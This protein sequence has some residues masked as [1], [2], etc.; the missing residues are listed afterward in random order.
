MPELITLS[1]PTCGAKTGIVDSPDTSGLTR[2]HCEY[3][4]NDHLLN[5]PAKPVVSQAI[6]P[7]RP[8]IPIPESVRIEKDGK[9]AVIIQ[10]WFSW[11]YIPMVF[12]CLV[13]DSFLCFWYT[14]V[15]GGNA[16]WIF[17][18]FPIGHLAVGIGI[19]YSTLAGFL[20]RT[21]LELTKDKLSIWFESLPWWGEKTF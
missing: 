11:K 2:F 8:K 12:F 9:G 21:C 13:W 5:I 17:I 10:R 6:A 1:C 20:N 14:A 3:C 4:G 19:T 15:L 7:L 18:V 16:P